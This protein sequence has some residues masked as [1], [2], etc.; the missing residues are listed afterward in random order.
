MND[1]IRIWVQEGRCGFVGALLRD[2]KRQE[3]MKFER[4]YRMRRKK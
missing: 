2:R 4:K 1:M 3:A